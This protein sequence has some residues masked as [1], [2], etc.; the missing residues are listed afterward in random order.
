MSNVRQNRRCRGP[1][2]DSAG[3]PWTRANELLL[4]LL[5]RSPTPHKFLIFSTM[6]GE[7]IEP[8]NCPSAFRHRPEMSILSGFRGERKILD[9]P[10]W[11]WMLSLLLSHGGPVETQ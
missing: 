5:S 7:G 6:H 10:G 4:Y 8:P 3:R 1:K 2:T 11:F 9:C